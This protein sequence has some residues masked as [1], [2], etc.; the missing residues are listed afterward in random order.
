[1]TDVSG[2][3]VIS[4]S[5]IKL[6]CKNCSL[7]QLCLP[8]GIGEEDMERLEQIITRRRPIKRGEH[9]FNQ[10]D[11]FRSIYAIRAGSIKTYTVSDDGSEQVTGFHL[12]G[13][14]VGL[15]A[16]INDQH[17]CGAKALETTSFCE[18]PFEQLEHLAGELASLRH[19][20]LRIM[21]KEIVA[22]QDLLML[23]GKK[24]AEARLATFLLSLSGRFKERGFSAVEFRLTM[25]RNDI[26][27]YLGLAVETVSRLF[28]RFQEQGL[29][30]ADGKSIQLRDLDALRALAGL[31]SGGDRDRNPNSAL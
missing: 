21:G 1:M 23:L 27:N 12:P 31:C 30:I 5:Q 16:V 15:D 9:L 6:A 20:L 2:N 18:I 4:L 7:H 19:Q 3:K 29:V 25:S 13:E 10:G 28:T 14:L 22:E 24:T 17:P 26:G 8:I 11:R